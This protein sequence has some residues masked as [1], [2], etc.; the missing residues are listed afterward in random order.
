MSRNAEAIN[1]ISP[2]ALAF[3]GLLCLVVA[4]GVGRFAY[5]PILP[6]MVSSIG[7]SAT[8]AGAI[9]SANYFGYLV[10]A[11]ILSFRGTFLPPQT[12]LFVS[13]VASV[14]TTGIMAVLPP[15]VSPTVWFGAIRFLSGVTSAFVL[16]LA[17][18]IVIDRLQAMG[19][20]QYAALHWGG[21]GFGIALSAIIVSGVGMS[22]GGWSAEWLACAV[23]CSVIAL[24][25]LRIMPP[26]SRGQ[27]ESA[28]YPALRISPAF[29]MIFLSYALFGFG[30][31]ITAT[32]IVAIVRETPSIA[33]LEPYVWLV[34]G[35]S[36]PPANLFWQMLTER[37]GVFQAT[38]LANLILA[39][40]VAASVL[41]PTA[42]GIMFAA[43]CL[44]ATIASIAALSIGAA[45]R[46][47]PA[48]PRQVFGV[49][50]VGFGIGQCV[51]PYLAGL[52]ADRMGDFVMASMM[53]AAAQIGAA[54]FALL[55]L[56]F[57]RPG[58]VPDAVE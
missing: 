18:S 30:Y 42:S 1:E 15:E 50:T 4:M 7:L 51:G 57:S 33:V 26:P 6:D 17:S 10:G 58:A 16:V 48:D 36:L 24:A 5:T 22:G 3:A 20:S 40:G 21:V 41:V 2:F 35:L 47:T 37:V 43:V 46:L 56:A 12:L 52:V 14:L 23:V 13:L 49:M 34:V 38:A 25:I 28:D 9:A 29:V 32:F 54:V 19:R 53:G 11:L 8:Q 55:A 44:G 39:F 31:V 45:R 27:S